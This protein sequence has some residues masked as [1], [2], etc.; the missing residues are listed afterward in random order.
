MLQSPAHSERSRLN[1][2]HRHFGTRRRDDRFQQH[3]EEEL[4]QEEPCSRRHRI[5]R[6]GW[7]WKRVRPER[8]VATH[9]DRI[10]G[11]PILSPKLETTQ[12]VGIRTV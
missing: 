1:R 5:R 8:P 12:Y 6:R 11:G 10:I 7:Q 2:G 4:G 9:I 3:V